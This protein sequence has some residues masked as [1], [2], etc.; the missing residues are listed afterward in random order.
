MTAINAFRQDARTRQEPRLPNDRATLTPEW[1]RDSALCN[2][3]AR[4]Q[5]LV[6]AD[7][8]AA[9]ALCPTPDELRTIYR[10]QF[11]VMR[12][13]EAETYDAN[14]HIV[15]TPSKGLPRKAVKGDTSYTLTTPE[16]T[17]Q[18]IAIGWEDVRD[19]D[20]S[21]ITRRTT[22]D[23]HSIGPVEPQDHVRA[24]FDNLQREQNYEAA[25]LTD[26]DA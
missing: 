3:C 13:C 1:H 25:W 22:Q 16:G 8:L 11:H 12:Q 10:V 5:A 17:K 19:L 20:T 4:R 18:G 9:K 23:T 15:F 24:P 21:T 6:E 2:D 26:Q 14:G 7:A